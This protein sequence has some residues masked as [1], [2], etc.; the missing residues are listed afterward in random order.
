MPNLLKYYQGF[1][2]CVFALLFSVLE[3]TC[4]KANVEQ[5]ANRRKY[6]GDTLGNACSWEST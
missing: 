4:L 6:R 3:E 2:V 1:S 5:F